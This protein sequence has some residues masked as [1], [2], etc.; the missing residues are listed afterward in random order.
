MLL[1]RSTL[2]HSIVSHFQFSSFGANVPTSVYIVCCKPD[3]YYCSYATKL[4]GNMTTPSKGLS[5]TASK[6]ARSQDSQRSLNPSPAVKVPK[7]EE[8]PDDTSIPAVLRQTKAGTPLC[9]S[10]LHATRPAC[11]K[12]QQRSTQSLKSWNGN[13]NFASFKAVVIQIR[14]GR[15]RRPIK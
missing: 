4:S 6:R 9:M 11:T 1:R 12:R 10:K 14:N 7:T 2:F 5:S 15:R 3:R 13:S 8:G